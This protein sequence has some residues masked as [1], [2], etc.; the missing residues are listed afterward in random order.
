MYENVND[1]KDLN[2]LNLD[3]KAMESGFVR[4]ALKFNRINYKYVNSLSNH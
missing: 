3:M 1:E 4:V 2:N